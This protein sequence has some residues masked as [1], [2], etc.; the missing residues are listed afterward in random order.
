MI[1]NDFLYFTTLILI[2]DV[3]YSFA[4][5][6]EVKILWG[7]G[8]GGRGSDMKVG[9]REPRDEYENRGPGYG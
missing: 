8:V 5:R 3:L 9:G 2:Y 7:P 6:K 1:L 4:L